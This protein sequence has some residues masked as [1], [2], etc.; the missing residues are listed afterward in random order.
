MSIAVVTFKDNRIARNHAVEPVH[1]DIPTVDPENP[2]QRN[3]D[4]LTHAIYTTARKHC[5][6]TGIEVEVEWNPGGPISGYIFAG[7]HTAGQFTVEV[8][9]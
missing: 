1:Y 4:H 8:T 5:A 9:P 7:M 6:S 2:T 3:V